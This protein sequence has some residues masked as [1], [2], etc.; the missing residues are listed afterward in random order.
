MDEVCCQVAEQVSLIE[1]DREEARPDDVAVGRV[2]RRRGRRSLTGNKDPIGRVGLCEEGNR[3]RNDDL[4]IQTSRCVDERDVDASDI[5]RRER[6]AERVGGNGLG[7]PQRRS[8]D[9]G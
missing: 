3:W 2:V 9:R 7:R 1:L 5:T 6:G 8:A 4:G